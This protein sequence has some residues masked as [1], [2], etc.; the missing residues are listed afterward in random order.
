[1]E[2]EKMTL[3]GLVKHWLPFLT[4][5]G[6]TLAYMV[7]NQ[8][9]SAIFFG[10]FAFFTF[11]TSSY[12]E[13]VHAKVKKA[14]DLFVLLVSIGIRLL[15]AGVCIAVF[16]WFASKISGSITGIGKYEGENAEYWYNEYDAIQGD[17]EDFHSC[18]DDALSYSYDYADIVDATR[19]CENRYTP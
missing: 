14:W 13:W 7:A 1:M 4:F 12:Q 5:A 2:N 8:Y 19:D 18:I 6:L 10:A 3:M 11:P 17:Y 16:L 9:Q 15:I